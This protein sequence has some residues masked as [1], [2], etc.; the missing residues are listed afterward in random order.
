[1]PGEPVDKVVLTAV[2]LV[3]DHHDVAS[4]GKDRVPVSLLF[5]EE[6]LDCREHNAAGL[7][8]QLGAQIRPTLGLCRWLAKNVPAP[9]KG[10]EELVVQVVAVGKHDDRGVGHCRVEDD[11]SRVEG[12]RQALARPLR[13]PNHTDPPVAGFAP[14]PRSCLV[15]ARPL[16]HTAT[17]GSAQRFLDGDVHSVKLMVSRLLLGQIPAAR[18][19]KDDEVAYQIQETTV[20]E[21]PF[22]HYLQLREMGR[23]DFPSRD[24]APRLEPLPAGAERTDPRLDAV[25]DD[26]RGIVGEERRDLDLVGLELLE[27]A[28]DGCVLVSGILQLEDGERQPVDEH[29]HVRPSVVLPLRNRELVDGQPVVALEYVKVK[30]ARLRPSDRAIRSAVLHRHT[31]HQQVVN[32]AVAFDQRRCIDAHHLAKGV[33]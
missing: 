13:V 6:L 5:R 12:H 30:H 4:L 19:L 20:V 31:I 25:G 18:V 10:A 24:G 7:H 9:R 28:P 15:P 29:H 14:G 3:G 8:V 32:G 23:C 16:C 2:R 11:L 33:V 1:M 22:Q 26:E 21:H 17:L 27:G